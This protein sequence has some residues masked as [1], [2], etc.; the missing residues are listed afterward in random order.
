MSTK[1]LKIVH[2][3]FTG[4]ICAML[5]MSVGMYLTKTEEIQEILVGLN[6]PTW[7]VYHLAFAKAAGIVFILLRKWPKITEWAYAGITFNLCLAISAHMYVADGE[8]MGA[9][10]ALIL[11]LGSY[12]TKRM[13][14]KKQ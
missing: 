14:E 11:L 6:F 3:I 13:L 10:M 4:L 7:L 5:A 8:Q 12:A 9:L 1:T 2:W